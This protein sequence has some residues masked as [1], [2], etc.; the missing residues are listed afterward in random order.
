MAS[1][2]I[3]TQTGVEAPGGFWHT[4]SRA[5]MVVLAVALAV[6][7]M[8]VYA[9]VH[10]HPWFNLDDSFYVTDNV[11]I[12]NGLDWQTIKWSFTTFK[13]VNW[14]PVT[15]MAHAVDWSLFGDNPAGHHDV[16][17]L[18]HA[19]DA[20]LLMWLLKRATGY[21]YRSFMVAALFALHPMNVESV[22]WVA[23]RKTMLSMFFALL[24]LA[25]YQWYAEKP[26]D[27]KRYALVA[28]FFA[29]GLL[30]KSQIITLPF[31][32][33]LWDYWPLQRMFPHAP[34]SSRPVADYPPETVSSLVKEKVPLLLLA[35]ADA[36]FTLWAQSSARSRLMPPPISR[37]KNALYS[38]VM[39]VKKCFWPS[40][41]APE[42]PHMGNSLA[43]W[44]VL[45]C[46][47][48]LAAITA[49][50]LVAR[51]YRY[52]P[53]GWFW[54]LGV[55]VPMIG[56]LQVGHQGMA[57]RYAYQ[58]FIGIFIMVCW[59]VSDWT[60]QRRI[61][62]RWLAAA[63]AVVLVALTAVTYRQIG[64][65]K[66][67]WTLWSHAAEVIPND[68]AAITNLGLVLM[69]DG[70]KAEAMQYFHKALAINPNEGI[71][72]MFVGY[73]DQS[74]GRPQQAIER[75]QVALEEY[76]ID[77][78]TRAQIWRN[79]AVAYH[80]L[81]NDAKSQECLAKVAEYTNSAKQP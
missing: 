30:A 67:D 60:A 10:N 78:K 77:D 41:M 44:Q 9:P 73:Q 28:V 81:G 12:H 20:V 13:M 42:L 65:W 76:N 43:A 26:K 62:V 74:E 7:T 80:A 46:V 40:G 19:L 3:K 56:I 6:A 23:E 5:R 63:S 18:L 39:Y 58:A 59:G 54:F 69:R 50:V 38:Y 22:A 45:G 51:R 52:L 36:V 71:C 72:N 35:V 16:N 79:M 64:F 55:L 17:V 34:S 24:A 70:K 57:D 1:S 29:L 75:Y 27:D 48:V 33:L 4:D 25:A 32:F 68:D 53:V 14:I 2:V 21:T 31:V 8:I 11:H 37:V 61:S 15:W 47:I 49:L 66:D